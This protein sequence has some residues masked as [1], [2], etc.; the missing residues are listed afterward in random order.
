MYR[1]IYYVLAYIVSYFG[2]LLQFELLDFTSCFCTLIRKYYCMV[3]LS[4]M[5]SR[6]PLCSEV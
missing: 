2:I 1:D 4:T 3:T 5:S 6:D